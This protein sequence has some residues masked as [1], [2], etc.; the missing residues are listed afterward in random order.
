MDLPPARPLEIGTSV[1]LTPPRPDRQ[2]GTQDA[3]RNQ[4]YARRNRRCV[5]VRVYNVDH[6]TDDQQRTHGSHQQRDRPARR[7]SKPLESQ[8]SPVLV[9]L[10][11]PCDDY[12]HQRQDDH[13]RKKYAHGQATLRTDTARKR[14]IPC[15]GD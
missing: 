8:R 3:K 11:V 10:A 2:D 14:H 1:R 5:C 7:S 4:Y 13:T 9:G 12:G 15:G 6:A